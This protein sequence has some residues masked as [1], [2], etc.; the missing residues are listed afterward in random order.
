M[1][2][3][4]NLKS[5]EIEETLQNVLRKD[6]TEE[7]V[8]TSDYQPATKKY[9]DNKNPFILI[10]TQKAEEIGDSPSKVVYNIDSETIADLNNIIN[11]ATLGT[12]VTLDIYAMSL[13]H[14]VHGI[15]VSKGNGNAL[16]SYG[17]NLF[18]DD[19]TNYYFEFEFDVPNNVYTLSII[20]HSIILTESDYASLGES[21]NTD[22]VLYFVTPDAE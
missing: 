8:P 9:V 3:K 12:I 18:T 6:N 1:S 17:K 13:Y 21:V 5:Q 11:N 4:S 16:S 15:V 22:N 20:I 14:I 19:N 2:F 7:F 10:D